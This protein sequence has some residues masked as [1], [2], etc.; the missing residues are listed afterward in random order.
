M[1]DEIVKIPATME[2][3]IGAKGEMVKPSSESVAALVKKVPLGKLTTLDLVRDALARKHKVHTARP[4]ATTKALLT[5]E[6]DM[7]RLCYLRVLKK[8][9]SLIDKLP[10]A[11]MSKE[12]ISK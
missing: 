1:K 5:A 9:G 11:F 2:K 6:S 8:D 7:Q 3:F 12:D 4:V 10:E